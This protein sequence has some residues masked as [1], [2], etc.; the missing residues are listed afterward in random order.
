MLYIGNEPILSKASAELLKRAGYR[1]RIT[2]PLH[3]QNAI[4]D[5]QFGAVILCATLSSDE[6]DQVVQ[7]VAEMPQ[8]PPVVSIHLGLLGDIP[9]P[10]SSAFVD[11]LN[12]PAALIEVVDTIVHPEARSAAKAV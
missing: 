1:V 6:A 10:E 9:N 3:A 5:G 11:A 4:R 2:T 8:K 12:G 7:A